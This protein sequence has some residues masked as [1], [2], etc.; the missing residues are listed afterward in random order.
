MLEADSFDAALFV[1]GDHK[2]P[3][4][5]VPRRFLDGINPTP[6]KTTQSGRLE[7]AG[8]IAAPE[9][10]LT[11]RVIVNRLW[12]HVFGRGIVGT[13]DNF[14]RLGELPTH[15]ELLDLLAQQFIASGGSMRQMIRALVL[16]EAFQRSAQSSPLSAQKDPE[17][18]LL[19][20]WG[21]R[22]L[23]AEAIRD[24]IVLLSG[25]LELTLF[26]EPVNDAD[27]RRS[28]YVK[29]IRNQLDPFLTAFDLPV[30]S[31][32][33]GRRD[34][35]NVP[36]Q[37]L[38]LL[39]DPTVMKWASNWARTTLRLPDKKARVQRMFSEALGREATADEITASLCFVKSS[40]DAAMRQQGELRG[41][42]NEA[43]TIQQQMDRLLGPARAKLTEQR[44]SVAVSDVPEPLAEWDFEKDANDLKGRL[45]LKLEGAARIEHGALVLDGRTASA[46]SALLI[47]DLKAKTL[48]AWVLLDTLDQA[49]GGVVTVQDRRGG[50]FDSIVYAERNARE[51]LAGSDHHKRTQEFR[52]PV[53][54]DAAKRPV[55][56]AI[57]YTGGKVTGYRDGVL[58]GRLF[59]T[60][61]EAV[62]K[63]GD[64]EVLLGCRHGMAGGNKSLRGR[65]LRAR[66]YDRALTSTQIESSRQ[67]EASIITE[68]DVLDSLNDA[69]RANV[70]QWQFG[71]EKLHQQIATLETR[72]ERLSP[73]TAGWE[74]LALSI[75]NLKEFVY[76]R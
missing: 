41:L 30:P 50:V 16:T 34:V 45:P 62:F 11:A 67:L 37:S 15:P 47:K 65:I 28:I 26:G 58:Y 29:V 71:L 38:A 66:L 73:E 56:V 25:K 2:Q 51:W 27:P 20:H 59:K 54:S 35:T 46:R 63:A 14:G 4:E 13:P 10:P 42:E 48:E 55:H 3:S 64:A 74:S 33:R 31:S 6:F 24:S 61:D 1:R 17:N 5:I 70:R 49:G 18:K 52:G 43:A 69:D 68:R 60:E 22:R 40:T 8:A 7:L 57:T 72:L 36:A 75:I 44:P 39:N 76:L 12:H 19:S 21:I 9:N 23:E 32:T 53:E